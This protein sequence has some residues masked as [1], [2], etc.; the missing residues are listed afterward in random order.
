[1]NRL[2]QTHTQSHAQMSTHTQSHAQMSTQ[3]KYI[4]TQGNMYI[5]PNRESDKRPSTL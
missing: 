5:G 2:K 3:T 4:G 1:M